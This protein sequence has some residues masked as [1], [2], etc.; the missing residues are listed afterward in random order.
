MSSSSSKDKNV[1]VKKTK[2]ERE[3]EWRDDGSKRLG[4]VDFSALSDRQVGDKRY[5][6]DRAQKLETQERGVACLNEAPP[7]SSATFDAFK[8]MAAGLEGRS[9]ADK[10]NDS[11][12]PTWEQYKKDNEDKLNLA[13]NEVKKMAQYRIELDK[14]R[15]RKLKMGSNNGKKSSAID[16]ES[17]EDSSDH[18]EKKSKKKKDKKKHSKHSS[19]EKKQHKKEKKKRRRDSDGDASS[20]E[21]DDE[22]VNDSNDKDRN[23]DRNGIVA[24][25]SQIDSAQNADTTS[26]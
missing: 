21:E 15:D 7:A 10:I 5:E 18:D 11:N 6:R 20:G 16:S 13:G 4:G 19:K 22:N 17:E 1:K 14:E 12:R 25:A 23:H 2:K 26:A 8:R 3:S 9:I 24:E